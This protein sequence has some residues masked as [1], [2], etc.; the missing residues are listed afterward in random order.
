MS[1]E[2][3]K[4]LVRSEVEFKETFGGFVVG[5][6]DGRYMAVARDHDLSLWDLREG[7]LCMKVDRTTGCIPAFIPGAEPAILYGTRDGE[8]F[9]VR[10]VNRSPQERLVGIAPHRIR[11]IEVSP[12]GATVAV[13]DVDLK[14]SV[15]ANW[16]HCDTASP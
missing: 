16:R 7:R 10:P 14:V 15:F 3:T 6:P 8:L 11:R 12:D 13:S 4:R 1:G 9:S 5:S 2:L